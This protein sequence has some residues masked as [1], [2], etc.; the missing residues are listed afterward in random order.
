MVAVMEIKGSDWDKMTES[1][2]RRNV[3]RQAR[4]VWAYIESQLEDGK[5]V[6]PGIVFPER[7]K[8]PGKL[9]F[10]ESFF[11]EEGIP[12]VWQDET[13]DERKRRADVV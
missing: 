12:V 6:C 4:Q 11:D 3:R 10:I 8:T 9:E 2:A 5:E 13:I 7:P 1:N